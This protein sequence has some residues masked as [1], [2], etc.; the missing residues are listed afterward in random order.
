MAKS[1]GFAQPGSSFMTIEALERQ[2]LSRFPALDAE[3]WDHTGMLVGDRTA[4][5]FGVTVALDPTVAAIKAAADNG[6]NV[7]VTHHPL[8]LDPPSVFGPLGIADD[9]AGSR[10]WEAVSQ[11]VAV[12]SFHTALDMSPKAAKVLPELLDLEFVG[13]L[14]QVHDSPVRGYGQIC[15]DAHSAPLT[16]GELVHRC[17]GA[18]DAKPRV[19]GN[20]DDVLERVVTCTGSAG[21]CVDLCL[22][23]GIDCLVCGEVHYHDAL[24]AAQEGL[25]IIELGHDISEFPLCGL[26]VS[27]VVETGVPQ[28]AVK[29]FDQKGNW[30]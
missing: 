17:V 1:D 5:V 30:A 12:M 19:W 2:L 23:M 15:F 14:E 9:A 25:R 7:L 28:S 24:D 13:I 3:A 22:D 18:F 29:L 8:F 21:E 20:A 10:V 26:L 27:S 6:S 4:P 11:S 16:L